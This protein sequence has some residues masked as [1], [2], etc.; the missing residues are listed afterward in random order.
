MIEIDPHDRTDLTGPWAGFGFMAEARTGTAGRPTLPA[1]E[2]TTTKSSVIYLAEVLRSRR[3]QRFGGRDPN[4]DAETSNVV[5][6]SRGPR[7]RQRV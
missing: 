3:E 2:S 5:Y 1:E 6:I 7:P 4:S